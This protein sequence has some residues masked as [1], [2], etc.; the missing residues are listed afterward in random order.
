MHP[1]EHR[2]RV[3]S[4]SPPGYSETGPPVILFGMH[5]YPMSKRLPV[6]PISTKITGC[7]FATQA[8]TLSPA[9]I[10]T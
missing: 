7:A 1:R 4:I 8:H 5:S 9:T 3:A 10:P 2:D 6:Q